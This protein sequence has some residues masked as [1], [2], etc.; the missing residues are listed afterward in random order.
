M[1]GQEAKK[2]DREWWA[3]GTE[4]YLGYLKAESLHV[5]TQKGALLPISLF[6]SWS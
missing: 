5:G 6:H 4:V 1:G 2:L 3:W